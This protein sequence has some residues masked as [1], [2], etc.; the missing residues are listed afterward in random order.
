MSGTVLF[1]SESEIEEI[2]RRLESCDF[3][4][5]EFTHAMHLAVAAWYLSQYSP[6][7]ALEHMR[8]ALVRLTNKFG[9]KA[10]HE[11]ITCFWLRAVHNFLILQGTERSLTE[12]VNQLTNHCAIKDAVYEYYSR[13]LLMSDA[14]RDNWVEPDLK[15][16]PGPEY[17]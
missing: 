9:V 1:R 16:L 5:G 3:E 17:R 11:T 15:L 2:V 6:Q 13:D 10:Y 7:E 14:A 12:S 4:K 8:S